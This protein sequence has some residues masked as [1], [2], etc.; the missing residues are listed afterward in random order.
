MIV[1]KLTDQRM[2]TRNGF[3]WGLGVTKHT[4]G[5]G[6]LCGPGWLHAYADPLVAVFMNPVHAEFRF[7]RLFEAEASGELEYD[8]NL[9]LG[10]TTLTLRI[11]LALPVLSEFVRARVA[12][13]AAQ[14]VLPDDVRPAWRSWANKWLSREDRYTGSAFDNWELLDYT[15][16]TDF[17]AASHASSACFNCFPG[18]ETWAAYSAALAVEKAQGARKCEIP[19]PKMIREAIEAEKGHQ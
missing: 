5:K 14:L 10:T 2:Q 13:K 15:L 3:Q 19:L 9:K 7:P 16:N 8:G 6:K 1:Y 4:S 12:I 11:E 17:W 18:H